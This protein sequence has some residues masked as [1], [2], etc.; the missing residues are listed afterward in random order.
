MLIASLPSDNAS[1]ISTILNSELFYVQ[2]STDN[3]LVLIELEGDISVLVTWVESHQFIVFVPCDL[4]TRNP[5]SVALKSVTVSLERNLVSLWAKRHD[6]Q[7]KF[8]CRKKNI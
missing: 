8:A 7:L 3:H 6:W 2:N 1:V 5:G 4:C